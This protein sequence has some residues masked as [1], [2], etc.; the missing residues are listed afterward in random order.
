MIGQRPLGRH[1]GFRDCSRCPRG[2]RCR[3]STEIGR[4]PSAGSVLL[5]DAVGPPSS[6]NSFSRSVPSLSSM[7][8]RLVSKV[9]SIR[10][11]GAPI[12]T[13]AAPLAVELRF[14]WSRQGRLA[15][16]PLFGG[17]FE[18]GVLLE[19]PSTPVARSRFESCSS[20]MACIS[21]GV[22]TSAW[23]WRIC[24]RCDSA[25]FPTDYWSGSC[26]S[27]SERLVYRIAV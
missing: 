23:L 17:A 7:A 21:C 9:S 26:L 14:R 15:G 11:A 25:M 2:R 6:G 13:G 5:R 8:L 22:I 20:L 16:P 10:S 27:N 3:H 18:R 24:R 4:R 12:S 1:E 19:L